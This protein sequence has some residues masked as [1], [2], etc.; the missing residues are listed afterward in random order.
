MVEHKGFRKILYF[1]RWQLIPVMLALPGHIAFVA[2]GLGKARTGVGRRIR[3]AWAAVSIH[4]RV[5]CKHNPMEAIHIVEEIIELPPERLGDIVECGCASGGSSAKLS[6]AVSM[7]G[8][9]LI[10]CDSFEGLPEVTD[11][12][13]TDI[14]P[15]FKKGEYAGRLEEV[16][17]NIARFGRVECVEFVKGWY[18]NSLGQL[19]GRRIACAFWDVDL[20]ESFHTCIDQLW[21][22]VE[23]G[24]KVFIHD[25][26]R[27]PVVE[28][29]TDEV[30]WKSHLGAVPPPLFG[31]L[32]GLGMLSPLL[33][34]AVKS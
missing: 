5:P 16:K 11:A 30:W 23:P 33:G 27:P 10:V 13:H 1:V 17:G 21:K 26:D 25:I 22:Q 14:K 28:V 15:D 31:G 7:V 6:L 19:T 29:F 8:R 4:L 3:L 34:Y 24:G 20:R 18:E 12:N 32:T 2:R 9:K